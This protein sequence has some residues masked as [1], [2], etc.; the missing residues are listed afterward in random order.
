MNEL[1]GII[2]LK[3]IE[4]RI[5]K[6]REKMKGSGL[7]GLLVSSP[8]NCFYLTMFEKPDG[9]FRVIQILLTEKL[10]FIITNPLY[11]EAVKNWSQ[12]IPTKVRQEIKI[13]VSDNK[14]PTQ[15]I[16]EICDAHKIKTLGFEGND[17]KILEY[18]RLN[19]SLKEVE[20]TA[21]DQVFMDLRKIKDGEELEN[22]KTAARIADTAF[23]KILAF[24]KP[25]MSEK[26]IAT[27]IDYIMRKNGADEPAFETIVASG[28]NSAI[29]HHKTSD[30]KLKSHEI[31]LLDF[32]AR[33]K[34]YCSDMSRMISLG[35][36]KEAE[37]KAYQLVLKAQEEALGKIRIGM[38]GA[39]ADSIS[40]NFLKKARHGKLFIH[41]LGHS[42]GLNIHESP[43]IGPAGFEKIEE[44]MVFSVEPGV[45]FTGKFGIRIEDIVAVVN[46]KI[47]NLTHSPKELIEI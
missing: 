23:S 15:I 34:G 44:G 41:N 40:R 19:K 36:P 11:A 46:G 35:K 8:T 6:L 45:Y 20:L 42:L 43:N 17:L 31:V 9:N 27:E 10:F 25:G 7:D 12:K 47:E 14:T 4:Q 29:P 2:T 3:M 16:T 39:E 32:G 21:S 5:E 30:K 22:I 13:K 26:E 24:I 33:Y 38:T 37:I 18:L 1:S 28:S